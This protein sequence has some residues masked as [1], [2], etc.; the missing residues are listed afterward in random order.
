[1]LLSTGKGNIPGLLNRTDEAAWIQATAEA[2]ARCAQ[3]GEHVD[4]PGLN[5]ACLTVRPGAAPPN[6]ST[7]GP[8]SSQ[9]TARASPGKSIERAPRHVARVSRGSGLKTTEATSPQRLQQHAHRG[10]ARSPRQPCCSRAADRLH[11]A[12]IGW[13]AAQWNSSPPSDSQAQ[14]ES[15]RA[16]PVDRVRQSIILNR[17][18]ILPDQ[19]ARVVQLCCAEP[20]WLDWVLAQLD[21]TG[22]VNA[23]LTQP[24]P[25]QKSGCGHRPPR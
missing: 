21:I 17:R 12:G 14:T 24:P 7:K 10:Q 23:L 1:M 20:R 22:G 6:T 5:G 18:L 11:P 16:L 8:T 3:T 4:I 2:A 15:G 19:T 9:T 13:S 25:V